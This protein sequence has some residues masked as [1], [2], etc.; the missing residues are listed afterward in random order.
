MY[1][2]YKKLISLLLHFGLKNIDFGVENHPKEQSKLCMQIKSSREESTDFGE[3]ASKQFSVK[4]SY[5]WGCVCYRSHKPPLPLI[6]NGD[7]WRLH[8][9][10]SDRERLVF[11]LHLCAKQ[12]IPLA[13]RKTRGLILFAA[14][15]RFTGTH[16]LIFILCD[17]GCEAD[18]LKYKYN[19]AH[20]VWLGS[21]SRRDL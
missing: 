10:Q 4:V 9:P 6:F 7:S 11:L 20:A 17:S 5:F 8:H 21:T 19:T 18:R 1:H 16:I 2:L 15:K 12:L 3:M 13:P 14:I